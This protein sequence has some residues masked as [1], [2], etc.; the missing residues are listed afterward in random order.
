MD[1]RIVAPV[2]ISKEPEGDLTQLEAATQEY[3]R[4][5]LDK[6]IPGS[7]WARAGS[8][9]YL[10][11]P[12]TEKQSCCT[13]VSPDMLYQHCLGIKH[14]ARTFKVSVHGLKLAINKAQGESHG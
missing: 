10:V 7:T 6:S 14:I 3:L 9:A 8:K 12:E 1:Q 2:P 11:I 13:D 4:R 5:N